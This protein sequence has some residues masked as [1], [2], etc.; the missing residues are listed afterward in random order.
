MQSLDTIFEREIAGPAGVL[1]PVIGFAG[2]FISVALSPWFNWLDNAL[3]DLG[4]PLSPVFWLF[5]ST[6]VIAGLISLI[7]VGHL[8]KEAVKER[9]IIGTL[10]S[11]MLFI[12]FILLMGVGL[13]NETI[14]PYH[15]TIALG[16]FLA[17]IFSSIIYGIHLIMTPSRRVIGIVAL[18]AGLFDAIMLFGG[19]IAIVSF[20]A[21]PITGLAIPEIVLA[22]I[23]ETW[24]IILGYHLYGMAQEG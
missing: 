11:L 13:V 20:L 10:G 21:I 17:L 1:G 6:L 22:L 24:I 15:T 18:F 23:G 8:V 14:K 19:F 4:H 2:I 12:S 3:S 7:F 9:S 5:N 16:F